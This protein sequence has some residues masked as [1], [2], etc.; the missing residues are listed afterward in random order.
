MGHGFV[1]KR[2]GLGGVQPTES[3]GA[4]EERAGFSSVS[5]VRCVI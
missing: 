1:G 3:A 4:G 2:L 5:H